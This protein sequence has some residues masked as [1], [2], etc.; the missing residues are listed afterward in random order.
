MTPT[1]LGVTPGVYPPTLLLRH[2]AAPATALGW[3]PRRSISAQ[4]VPAHVWVRVG[5]VLWQICDQVAADRLAQVWSHCARLLTP[6][7]PAPRTRPSTRGH[8]GQ[9]TRD[10]S[11]GRGRADAGARPVTVAAAATDPRGDA[12]LLAAYAGGDGQALALLVARRAGLV[13]GVAR[14]VLGARGDVEDV[15]QTT[16]LRVARSAH[17]FR[18]QAAVTTWLWRIAHHAALD[19]LRGPGGPANR[20]DPVDP[21]TLAGALAAPG[22]AHQDAETAAEVEAL[23]A[24]LP[25]AQRAAVEL[26]DLQG[27]DLASAAALLGA[28]EATVKSRRVRA[29]SAMAAEATRRGLHPYLL[30]P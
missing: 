28:P 17:T 12:E 24:V 6:P 19:A 16:W 20:A 30:D 21:E 9:S 5:P 10:E 22:D 13:T 18:G 25:A 1:W 14:R 23:L 3:Q 26:V 11:G 15:A 2:V 27:R 8:R 4:I 29:R 7:P